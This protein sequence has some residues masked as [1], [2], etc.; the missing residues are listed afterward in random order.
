MW[1]CLCRRRQEVAARYL[2]LKMLTIHTDT[3]AHSARHAHPVTIVILLLNAQGGG[4]R[5]TPHILHTRKDPSRPSTQTPSHRLNT[6]EEEILS[7]RRRKP[8]SRLTLAAR[9][10]LTLSSG[11]AASLAPTVTHK[12]GALRRPLLS[13]L[14][15]PS[16]SAPHETLAAGVARDQ[17]RPRR[18]LRK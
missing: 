18:V 12:S 7:R 8:L 9:V 5:Y 17:H 16:H 1:N 14:H 2:T 10:L 4:P 13:P 6:E 3:H 11:L 15:L